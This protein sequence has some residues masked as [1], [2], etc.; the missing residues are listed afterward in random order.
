MI[1]H[2][3]NEGKEWF[4]SIDRGKFGKPSTVS[5]AEQMW[6]TRI[7]LILSLRRRKQWT[8]LRRLLNYLQFLRDAWLN[9]QQLC[10]NCCAF[11]PHD[12]MPWVTAF[13][14]I[15]LFGLTLPA[16]L[17][18]V[19]GVIHIFVLIWLLKSV[20]RTVTQPNN[21]GY[22]C[23]H[24]LLLRIKMCIRNWGHFVFDRLI[25]LHFES[26]IQLWEQK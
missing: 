7:S 9:N 10:W 3:K 25:I 5:Q 22:S 11:Y 20:K 23:M 4:F 19:W 16:S 26:H 8:E 1:L 2:N 15:R 13:H 17:P 14:T 18:H 24:T 21:P 6:K 12:A